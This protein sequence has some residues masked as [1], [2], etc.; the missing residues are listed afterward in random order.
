[1]GYGFID[2]QSIV[3]TDN[4]LTANYISQI[5]QKLVHAVT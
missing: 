4:Q 5:S 3:E 1:M 2:K